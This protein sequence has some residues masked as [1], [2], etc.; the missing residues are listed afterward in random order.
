MRQIRH[1]RPFTWTEKESWKDS[2]TEGREYFLYVGSVH[3][4]KN[5]INLLKAFSGFKKRQ[6]TNMQLVIAGRMAWQH[7]D[8]YKGFIHF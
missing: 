6:K 4:R 2:F 5:L 7:E 8:F 1:F 3:P